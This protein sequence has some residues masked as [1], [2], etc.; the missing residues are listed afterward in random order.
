MHPNFFLRHVTWICL[1]LHIILMVVFPL[2]S[3][4][5]ARSSVV[6]KPEKERA[7]CNSS[8][9]VRKCCG[10]D[11]VMERASDKCVSRQ[12]DAKFHEMNVLLCEDEFKIDRPNNTLENFE[13]LYGQLCSAGKYILEVDQ[14]CITE[15]GTLLYQDKELLDNSRYCLEE[16]ILGANDTVEETN[17]YYSPSVTMFMCMPEEKILKNVNM[18]AYPIGMI[19]SIPFLIVTFLTYI[20]LPELHDLHGLSVMC[21]VFCLFLADISLTI[22]QLGSD[23]LNRFR[24]CCVILGKY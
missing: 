15:L 8:R 7:R 4:L 16:Y 5:F 1:V 10:V 21:H 2:C 14:A 12:S 6:E 22:T 11:Q 13:I 9:C 18:K 17:P 3:M 23:F 24:V 20:L 19:A